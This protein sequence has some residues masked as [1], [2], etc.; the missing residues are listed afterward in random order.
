MYFR[1]GEGERDPERI[2]MCFSGSVELQQRLRSRRMQMA[3]RLT[4]CSQS[5]MV[6]S[7][8]ETD[9]GIAC[10]VVLGDRGA[11]RIPCVA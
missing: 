2:H 10:D 11:F 8:R 4:V 7:F 9:H 6:L 3:S 5:P 1:P